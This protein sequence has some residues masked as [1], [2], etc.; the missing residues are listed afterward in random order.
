MTCINETGSEAVFYLQYSSTEGKHVLS[1]ESGGN[2]EGRIC[3]WYPDLILP[4]CVMRI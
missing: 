4:L 2:I 1:E 3:S